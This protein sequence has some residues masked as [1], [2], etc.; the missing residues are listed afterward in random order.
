MTAR[1]AVLHTWATAT[2]AILITLAAGCG[3]GGSDLTIPGNVATATLSPTRTATS[4]PTATPTTVSSNA[5]AGLVVV[6]SDVAAQG[7]VDLGAPPP[8]WGSKGDEASFEHSLSNAD[9]IVDENNAKVGVTGKDGQF[10]IE[11]LAP[12]R[13]T[14]RLTKTVGGNLVPIDLP[15]VVGADGS[16]TVR[17]EVG[18]GLLRSDITYLQDGHTIREIHGPYATVVVFENGKV[19]ELGD[20][21]ATYSDLDRDGHFDARGCQTSTWSCAG[22]GGCG[23]AY[24][25][26]CLAACP[27]CDNCESPGICVD[28]PGTRPYRCSEDSTCKMPGDRCVC[29]PSC[30]GCDDCPR[31]AC[32]PSCDPIDLTDITIAIQPQLV[33]GRTVQAFA[34][35]QLSD[36]SVVDVTY[37]V[38]WSSSDDTIATVD[39]WGRINALRTGTTAIHA[40]LG[41]TDRS[42]NLAV[43]DRPAVRQ[44][45]VQNESCFCGPIFADDRASGAPGAA[46][47]SSLPPCY[48]AAPTADLLPRPNCGQVVRLGTTLQFGAYA[49]FADGSY[50]NVTDKVEWTVDPAASA[51]IDKGTFTATAAGTAGVTASLAGVSSDKLEIRIVAESTLVSLS[52]Y[53]GDIAYPAITGGPIASDGSSPCFDCGYSFTLLRGDMVS[54]HATAHYDTGEW[55]EVTK[56]VTWLS[57]DETIGTIDAS[58]VFTAKQAGSAGVTASLAGNNSDRVDLRIVNEA[59]LTNLSIYQEGGDR[60]V[61]KAD[62][63]FFHATA[64]YDVGISRDITPTATWKTSNANLASFDTPGV[65]TARAAGTVR[66]WAELNG[67]RSNE[68]SIEVFET[69]ELAY[70]DAQNVNR[71][72]WS[73]D[74]NRVTLESDCDTYTAPGLVTLR[75]SV[76][77]T[78]P[79]G[80]IFDP[81]LDLYVY[82]GDERVRTIREEGCGEP[83]LPSAAPGRDDAA[84]KYQL[85]AYWDLKDD[86]GNTVVPGD[87][88]IF[89]RFYLYYDPVVRIGVTVFNPDGSKPTPTARPTPKPTSTPII[90]P[91]RAVA[92][93][94]VSNTTLAGG[95]ATIEAYLASAGLAV[96]GVQVDLQPV[97][98]LEITRDT[99]G[100][101]VCKVNPAI[102]KPQSAFRFVADKCTPDGQCPTVRA[103]IFALDNVAPIPDGAPMFSCVVSVPANAP[104]GSYPVGCTGQV[105]SDPRGNSLPSLC[106]PTSVVVGT[107]PPPPTMIDADGVCFVGSSTCEASRYFPT[108]QTKC[109]ELASTAG[110]P[111]GVSWCPQS[112]FDASGACMTCSTPCSP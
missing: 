36:G 11:N 7:A 10:R 5:V 111:L 3:G 94:L 37:L 2:F 81:C 85:R 63:R 33:V 50:E 72:L 74:F 22:D 15:F 88:T 12:G 6:G 20:P 26:A 1:H 89:G 8:G 56:E 48:Y 41:D 77:E 32:L 44:L 65:L 110:L 107:T 108:L 19:V 60:V 47:P 100:A 18:Q 69:S 90:D 57:S 35:A 29:V 53:P 42:A 64:T 79:H 23:D 27:F 61:A 105:A 99:T 103:L 45:S 82:R 24:L 78:Q 96:A 49:E 46:L 106:N 95:S 54:F 55:R 21:R 25:C 71:A 51:T 4:R 98:P 73:D 86:R 91:M 14:L 66:L 83:F 30:E 16:A 43:V 92:I 9:W 31:T 34:T 87:Y 102:E 17:A 40:K 84:L 58:G 104:N 28:T 101:P 38:Q 97:A 59:T 76:T 109:C 70:C 62:Q 112:A 13:Y 75:Y 67:Q 68:L 93:R 80:G 52:I 39:S